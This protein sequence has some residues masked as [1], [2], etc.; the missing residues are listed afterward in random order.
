VGAPEGVLGVPTGTGAAYVFTGSGGTWTQQAKL[1]PAGGAV[2][3]V[4]GSR[5]SVNGDSAVV[6]ALGED[7]FNGAAYWFRRTASAWS[8]VA[9]VIPVGRGTRDHF[10]EGIAV[11]SDG[12][13]IGAP[14]ADTS[15]GV[16]AGV[17]YSLPLLIPTSV[18]IATN[19][20]SSAIGGVPILSGVVSPPELVGKNV[21]V[22]VKKPGKSYWSYSSWRTVYSRYGVPS[23]Q[24]K[25]FFK[26]GMTK[27]AYNYYA[28]V[29]NWPGYQTSRTPSQVSIRLR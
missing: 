19:K 2:A 28:I 24:Y 16:D 29:P 14:E 26:K 11:F 15:Y 23:W 21:M 6:A 27:G 10:G 3:G 22:M 13:L 12:V 9:R 25:Y 4:F 1:A 5:V 17:V 7:S 8:Q 18:T 20:T